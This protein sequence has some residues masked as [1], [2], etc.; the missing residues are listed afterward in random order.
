MSATD[1]PKPSAINFGEPQVEASDATDS[2][3]GLEAQ[4]VGL[5]LAG[6]SDARRA[7]IGDGIAFLA[8][9][10]HAVLSW[11]AEDG[12]PMNVDIE[13]DV[14]AAE[15]TVR[16]GEPAGFRIEAGTRVAITGSHVRALPEG[17]FDERSHVTVWGPAVSRPRGRFAVTP[18]RVWMWGERDLA[19][20]VSHD[21]RVAQA[22]RYYEALSVA[23]GVYT[24]PPLSGRL[25]LFRAV[26]APSLGT[27]LV[28]LLLGLAAALRAGVF[29]IVPAV[30]TMAIAGAV[31]LAVDIADGL[32]DLLHTPSRDGQAGER[33]SDAPGPIER[34]V[35]RVRGTPPEAIACFAVAAVLGVLL[36]AMR[37]STELILLAA[38]GVLLAGAYRTPP[39]ELADRGLGETAAA[40]GFGPV[41]LLGAYAVQSR[42]PVSGEAIV[43]SLAVGLLAGL[44]VLVNEIPSRAGDAAA[45]R[46]TLPARWPKA[47]V[48]RGYELA[49][50]GSFVAVG[51]G[52]VA[53]RLP[54]PVLLAL[55][56]APTA[57]RVRAGLIRHYGRPHELASVVATSVQ[58]HINVGLLLGGGYVLTIADQILLGRAPFLW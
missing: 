43:L 45:G 52:V 9:Y 54:L 37:G 50:G 27:T 56:A 49:C 32:F 38:V 8:A 25:A 14:K 16:F 23:R 15:G 12:Y 44:V 35:A 46:L 36:L 13:I 33:A 48:I 17:G 57:M 40:V 10:R 20:G 4:T 1:A 29:D 24:R 28:P 51:A 22:R 26:H 11:V 31:C 41:L 19:L 18:T 3:A 39:L 21:R 7:T 47:A 34:A 42:G 58:L 6:E 2:A 53:G 55:L 30:L 5:D